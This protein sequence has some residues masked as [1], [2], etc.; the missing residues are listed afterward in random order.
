MELYSVDRH[1]IIVPEISTFRDSP[2]F[3]APGVGYTRGLK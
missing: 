3:T 1:A 2:P